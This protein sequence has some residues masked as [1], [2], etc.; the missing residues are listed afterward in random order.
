MG[1]LLSTLAFLAVLGALAWLG[2][3][4]EPHWASKDGTRFMCRMQLSPATLEDRPRWFDVKVGVSEGELFVFSR[5]HRARDLRGTWRVTGAT[6]DD[7]K[8]RRIYELQMTDRA[9]ARDMRAADTTAALRVPKSSRCV[10]VLDAMIP[11]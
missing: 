6:N 8:K 10:P 2:W 3:G 7:A 11:Y 1:N 4:M 5:N 9:N